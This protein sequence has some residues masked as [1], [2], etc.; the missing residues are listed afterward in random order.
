MFK[1]P[2]PFKRTGTTAPIYVPRNNMSSAI[3][4][5]EYYWIKVHH[6]QAAYRGNVFQSARQLLT[7]SRVNLNHAALGNEEVFAL[8][9]TRQIKKGEASQ[10]GLAPNLVS[11]VPATMDHVSVTIEYILDLENR[12]SKLG[13]VINNDSLLSVI[14]LATGSAAVTKTIS[15]VAQQL[16]KTFVPAE[17]R[18]PLLQFSGDFNISQSEGGMRD[19]YYVIFGS[20]DDKHPLPTQIKSLKVDDNAVFVEGVP[21]TELSYVVLDV[22][23]V[24]VRTRQ[25][26]ANSNWDAKLREAESLVREAAQ[27]PFTDDAT[28]RDAWNKAKVLLR[29]ARAL[30]QTDGNY[31]PGE[32][33][34]IV[35]TSYKWC[36]DTIRG[37]ALESAETKSLI[38]TASD[39]NMLN[40]PDDEELDMTVAGYGMQVRAAEKL[41]ENF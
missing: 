18:K 23:R 15:G 27:D 2:E 9:R 1:Q 39:R 4:P 10:L 17:E 34:L 41:L 32:A 7:T 24:P 11:L 5:G 25:L 8:Q 22:Q 31:A 19:G 13:S 30:V 35:K 37:G 33:E 3:A 12:L 6:A 29:E 14:S 38:E 36:A 21:V 16:L 40:I 20:S 28:K 26:G